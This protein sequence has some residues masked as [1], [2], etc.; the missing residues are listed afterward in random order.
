MNVRDL[1]SREFHCRQI[2]VPK[3][4]SLKYIKAQIYKRLIYDLIKLT[5]E[6]QEEVWL[7]IKNGG[8]QLQMKCMS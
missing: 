2:D 4:E 3:C 8:Y 5:F 1:Y 6:W 7:A